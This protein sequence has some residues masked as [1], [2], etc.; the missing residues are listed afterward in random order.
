LTFRGELIGSFVEVISSDNEDLVGLKGKVVDETYNMVELENGK[1][2]VKD[3]VI[4][5]VANNKGNFILDGK[6][7]KGRSEDRIK[8]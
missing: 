6:L 8:K 1:R 3:Q 4:L 5:R 7:L 2:I